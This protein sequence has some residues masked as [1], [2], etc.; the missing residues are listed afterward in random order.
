MITI[1]SI[2]QY[3]FNE[4]ADAVSPSEEDENLLIGLF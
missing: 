3:N 1:L 2:H 4:K